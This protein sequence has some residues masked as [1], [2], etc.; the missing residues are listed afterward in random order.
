MNIIYCVKLFYTEC[1]GNVNIYEIIM[2]KIDSIF[3]IDNFFLIRKYD[4]EILTNNSG[5]FLLFFV[6]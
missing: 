5:F 4:Y 2:S 6:L 1:Y 3:D